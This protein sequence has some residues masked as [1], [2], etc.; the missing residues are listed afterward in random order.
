ML[1]DLHVDNN[2]MSLT[3]APG[4]GKWPIFH[5]P[6]AE[7]ICFPSIFCGQKCPSNNKRAY[8]VQIHELF[9]YELHSADTR[10]T[11]NI[12]NIFWKVKHKQIKQIV[13]KVSLAVHRN[14]TKGKKITAKML[15][16]KE[17]R[18]NIVKLDEG[19]Y[20]FQTI[21]NSPAYFDAKKKDVMAMV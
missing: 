17:Q 14:K 10:V 21:R 2:N 3:F 4:E 19:Y 20:I 15:L 9:K 6:L 5:E 8:P 1:D 11:S 16:D 13:D 12:P 7:Y 18:N